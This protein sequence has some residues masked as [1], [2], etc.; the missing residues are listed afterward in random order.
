VLLVSIVLA[1]ILLVV[2]IK[3]L[4]A[5]AQGVGGFFKGR[6]MPRELG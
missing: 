2:L 4:R 6:P 3:F 1:V 5:V